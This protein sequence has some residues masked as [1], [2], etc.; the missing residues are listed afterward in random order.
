[1]Q[2][3][4]RGM[5]TAMTELS[6]AASRQRALNPD[7]SCIVRAPAG[8]GKT[9][10]LIQRFLVMLARVQKPAEVLAITFTRKAA[11]EMRERILAA[12]TAAAAPLAPDASA[13][14]S[15]THA[16]AR[17]V[18]Q[19]DAELKWNL[20]SAPAQLRIQT[21]D[22]LNAELVRCM[23]WL[24]RLGALPKVSEFP[25]QHYL[26]AVNSFLFKQRLEPEITTALHTILAHLDNRSDILAGMLVDLLWRRDQWMRHL[27]TDPEQMRTALEQ[28]LQEKVEDALQQAHESLSITTAARIH[29]LASFA[30][31]HCDKG[32][33]RIR[34]Y[35]ATSF[36]APEA[37]ELA[38]WQ[39]IATMLLTTQE[40]WRKRMDKN[41]GFPA[42]K[43]PHAKQM[44]TEALEVLEELRLA[45]D[46]TLW[47]EVNLLPA[48]H[49]GAEAWEVLRAIVT[50]LP[51]LVAQ[52][53][54]EFRTS[55]EADF[56]EIAL[57]ARQALVDCGNP[58]DLLLQI[59][60]QI[61]HI[62][63]DEF[64]DTSWLQF[65]LLET[66]V[67]G[68][69]QSR[70]RTLFIVGDPMQ[71]IYRFR[72]AQ[73][74]L[75]LRAGDEGIGQIPLVP[76]QL[77]A[78]FRSQSNLVALANLW[79]A[80]VFPAHEHAAS[81]AVGFS[82]GVPVK[83]K[84]GEALCF[85][86][87][88]RPDLRTEADA[89]VSQVKR[90]LAA[91]AQDSVAILVRSRSHLP[92]ITALLQ[93]EA[94]AYQAQDIDPL[95]DKMAVQDGVSL[96]KA[97]LHPADKLSWLSVLRAPWCGLSLA[98]MSH[99]ARFAT[100]GAALASDELVT[101]LEEDARRRFYFVGTILL[102]GQQQRGRVSVRHLWEE[103]LTAL[104]V[105]G[106]WSSSE[107]EN[108]AQLGTVLERCD[109]G[110]DIDNFAH[111]EHQIQLLF[112]RDQLHPDA[113]VHVMTIHKAKGL[114]FDHVIL[115]GLGRRARR[116]PKALL[117]WEEDT[118]LG[119]LLAPLAQRGAK[120][121]DPVYA[122]LERMDKRKEA[123]ETARL[124]YVAVTRARKKLS[125]YAYAALGAD[126]EYAPA[127]GSLLELLWPV[128]C[129]YFSSGVHENTPVEKSERREDGGGYLQR[130]PL[131]C[132]PPVT[133]GAGMEL[134]T[135]HH[136]SGQTL[137][138]AYRPASSA[139]QRSAILGT[140]THEYLAFLG[141][142]PERQKPEYVETLRAGLDKRFSLAGYVS[143]AQTMTQECLVM[144]KN[145]LASSQ[146]RWILAQ[147]N[148]RVAEFELCGL[149]EGDLITGVVDLT[150][151]D[152]QTQ[153]RW[154]VDYKTASPEKGEA[155]ERFYQRQAKQHAPQLERYRTLL[156]Q[157][158]AV[159]C[160]RAGLFFPAFGGWC[161]V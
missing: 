53:W 5:I 15:K 12:L 44:K 155:E 135:Q 132:F 140:V 83:P 23:P 71:S 22:S 107:L 76:L 104:K 38:Q 159:H 70:G 96:L 100:I 113:R 102:R 108:L 122:M 136:L 2:Q 79:F 75:F 148:A 124:L 78:N 50:V 19:R 86:P 142:D 160:C 81:G 150:F 48:P 139:V 94:I 57:S 92:E 33:S 114:E 158:D 14:Q 138:S 130:L 65:S 58:T 40:Q 55:A 88:P 85:V 98:D 89:I 117:R 129:D 143:V 24:S 4:R 61:E 25:Q 127:A 60:Q 118:Q 147:H 77:T 161:E 115:P 91:N 28:S 103:C 123:Y 151:I 157:L 152:S 125:C 82:S 37:E 59:D 119:L 131:E 66:L 72:E 87:M 120:D 63:V 154:I 141:E 26:N 51:R 67:A 17:A 56:S 110:G 34:E 20:L 42:G 84:E 74:G 39:A 112:A 146:G 6:D 121:A 49:Y 133:H 64:Q 21:I 7:I 95:G 99:I 93:Q 111:M 126:G 116:S 30:A 80:T 97:L 156:Q 10:L 47:S 45:V 73:V 69:D 36:P 62:L 144:L 29:A 9:E 46:P 32:Q 43:D 16:L 27:L 128:C 149:C 18:L 106:C 109:S 145:T 54:L 13:H 3:E 137:T 68:W 134:G 35:A 8:S 1:M 41:C 11:A 153:E 52:L 31:L 105:Q 90:L 101:E